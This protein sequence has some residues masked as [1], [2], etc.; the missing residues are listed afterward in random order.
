MMIDQLP[1][2]STYAQALP[3][4]IHDTYASYAYRLG[5]SLYGAPT[6]HQAILLP[7]RDW[8]VPSEY[9]NLYAFGTFRSPLRVIIMLAER[10]ANPYRQTG[11]L[12]IVDPIL[13]RRWRHIVTTDGKLYRLIQQHGLLIYSSSGSAQ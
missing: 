6:I 11:I 5:D 13:S 4:A 9:L 1:P 12:P 8:T 2:F 3:D 10:L 7:A